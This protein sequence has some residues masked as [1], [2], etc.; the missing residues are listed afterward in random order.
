MVRGMC[1]SGS[2]WGWVVVSVGS[3]TFGER[4]GGCVAMVSSGS[5]PEES[6]FLDAS[7]SGG[8]VFFLTGARLSGL[9]RDTSLDVYD[10]HEC[11]AQSPCAG[12]LAVAPPA[13][14][15]EASCRPAPSP[16]PGV[17]GA[18]ASETFSG[19]GNVT[20]PAGSPGAVAL[21]SAQKLKLA[22][23]ACRREG[24]AC[25][26]QA[27]GVRTPGEGAVCQESER[28]EVSGVCWLGR[29]VA[30]GV[31]RAGVV[32]L[33]AHGLCRWGVWRVVCEFVLSAGG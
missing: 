26:A 19:A 28:Q 25:K 16:Q 30:G 15:T 22:L 29:G 6:A 18:P 27:C 8:D 31:A 14:V 3:A 9:D 20:A 13:C 12:G 11:S 33:R 23:A 10:A 7:D 4:S 2:L 24:Q 21:T 1:M 5:S 17:F 32:S